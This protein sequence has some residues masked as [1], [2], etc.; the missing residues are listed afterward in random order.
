MTDV[1]LAGL[2]LLAL[3][4]LLGKG[5]GLRYLLLGV[6]GQV[7]GYLVNQGLSV[8]GSYPMMIPGALK[9]ILCGAAP[10]PHEL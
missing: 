4:T 1:R 5:V 3:V 6:A 9:I 10:C 8:R 2:A 7:I